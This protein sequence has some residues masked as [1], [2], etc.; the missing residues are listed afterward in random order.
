M[1]E[2]SE[3][4]ER[5]Q[6]EVLRE[7]MQGEMGKIEGYLKGGVETQCSGN[8]LK[9]MKVTLMMSQN[10]E[11]DR[12]VTD[13]LSPNKAFNTRTGLYLIEFQAKGVHLPLG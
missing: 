11:G 13:H 10:N 3:E 7:G 9:Y 1:A 5:R 6:E 4:Q 8:F 2:S 12:A